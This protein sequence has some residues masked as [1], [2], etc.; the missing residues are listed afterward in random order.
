MTLGVYCLTSSNRHNSTAVNYCNLLPNNVELLVASG[1]VVS[2]LGSWCFFFGFE[3]EIYSG[4][5]PRKRGDIITGLNPVVRVMVFVG[6][7]L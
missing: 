7:A 3:P 6:C 5:T 4:T 2:I 1:C